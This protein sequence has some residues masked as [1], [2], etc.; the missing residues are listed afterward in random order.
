[1]REEH[2]LQDFGNK[3]KKIFE[4]MRNEVTEQFRILYNKEL[5]DLCRSGSIVGAGVAQSV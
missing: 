1:L 3:V 5:H 4:P 2:E